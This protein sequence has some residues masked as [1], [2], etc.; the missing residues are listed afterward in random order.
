[1][2]PPPDVPALVAVSG[3]RDSVALLHWL[4]MQ[5][6]RGLIVCH[7][8]HGLRGTASG[9]DAALVR[10]LAKRLDLPCEIE[11]VDVRSLAKSNRLSIETAAREARHEFLAAQATK[12]GTPHVFLAH[13]A[14]DQA[15]TVLANLCRGTGLGGLAGMKSEQHMDLGLIL[16]RPILTWRRTEIDH[17]LMEH[18]L[19]FRED[20]SNQSPAHRRN[21]LRHEVLP[22]LAEIFDRDIAANIVRCAA[23]AAQDDAGLKHVTTD[24][25]KQNPILEE[26]GGLIITPGLC[27][28]HPAIQ[29]RI[30]R[31]WLATQDV[32]GIDHA[33]VESVASMLLVSG[34]A[35]INLPGA[36]HL[37]RKARRLWVSASD[38]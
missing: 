16:H 37:R 15:E 12:H 5:G 2:M 28:V 25:L 36:R 8:N 3:G 18:R 21:R 30:L 35:K 14:E 33:L 23:I 7:L 6:R 10:R 38:D 26:D 22:L 24:W 19:P 1:M 32:T 11:K 17:Y 20:T 34:P 31:D 13:H 27:A 4:V 29:R 9:Q